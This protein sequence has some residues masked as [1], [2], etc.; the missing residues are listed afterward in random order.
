MGSPEKIEI[1]HKA[2][3]DSNFFQEKIVEAF[4]RKNTS[5]SFSL[6]SEDKNLKITSSSIWPSIFESL[7]FGF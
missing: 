2:N 3:F 1:I 5:D 6:Y 4:S 7:S